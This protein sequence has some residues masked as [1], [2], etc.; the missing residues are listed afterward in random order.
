MTLAEGL[1]RNSKVLVWTGISVLFM[2][3]A[4]TSSQGQQPIS[5]STEVYGV[6][7]VDTMTVGGGE[8]IATVTVDNEDYEDIDYVA[9]HHLS[10]QGRHILFR[11]TL[12]R[13]TT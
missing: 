1:V 4:V 3:V 9:A 8:I 6:E 12:A 13:A 7:V 5:T 11:G 2:S 10:Q